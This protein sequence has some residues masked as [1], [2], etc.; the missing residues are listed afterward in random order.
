MTNATKYMQAA[1]DH[2]VA[3]EA[4]LEAT[5]K[6]IFSGHASGWTETP[7]GELSVSFTVAQ[8]VNTWMPQHM[9]K[10]WRINGKVIAAAKLD[11]LLN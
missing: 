8:G 1:I 4:E 3:R 9:R 7:I 11:K 10:S 2:A 6:R 5:K